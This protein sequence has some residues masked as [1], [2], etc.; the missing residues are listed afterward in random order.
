MGGGTFGGDRVSAYLTD[1]LNFRKYLGTYINSNESIATV[2]KGDS[3]FIYRTKQNVATHKPD[4]EN[5]R[6][7]SV[8]D[9]RKANV[10]E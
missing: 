3:I 10:F 7:Y 4:I 9:L 1:S 5:T 2:C 8:Q 6:V